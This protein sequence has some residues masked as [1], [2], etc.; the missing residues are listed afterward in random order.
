MEESSKLV[1]PIIDETRCDGCGLCVELCST[2]ALAL[3]DGKA[4]VVNP[5]AC[6]YEGVCEDICPRG[7]IGR[8]FEVIL[9]T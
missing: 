4:V 3:R 1:T 8:P 9:A 7:A 5:E 2:E 6:L